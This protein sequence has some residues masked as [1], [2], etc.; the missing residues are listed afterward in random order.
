MTGTEGLGYDPAAMAKGLSAIDAAGAD[1]KSLLAKIDNVV[2]QLGASWKSQSASSFT[3]VHAKWSELGLKINQA[4]H[5][6]HE[7]LDASDRQYKA[8]EQAQVEGYSKLLGAI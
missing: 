3:Q 4:L 7:K 8:T 1:V 6:M 2:V 5:I